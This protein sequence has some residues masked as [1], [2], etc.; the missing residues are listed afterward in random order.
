MNFLRIR[1]L[2]LNNGNVEPK[3]ILSLWANAR[4][5]SGYT[6]LIPESNLGKCKDQQ[7]E[8]TLYR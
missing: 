2:V 5:K 1:L 8:T 6:L 7:T 4:Y 3:P